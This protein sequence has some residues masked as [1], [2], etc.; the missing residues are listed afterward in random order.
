MYCTV[1]YVLYCVVLPC[2][3]LY[4]TVLP[5]L[6]YCLHCCAV[7]TAVLPVLSVLSV[8]LHC[9][10]CPV[11]TVLYLSQCC[12]IPV[13]VTNCSLSRS[14]DES[15]AGSAACLLLTQQPVAPGRYMQQPGAA[16]VVHSPV[17]SHDSCQAQ[18]LCLPQHGITR[19][20]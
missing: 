15:A 14:V 7:C 11:C 12:L 19:V 16:A 3:V 10:Y 8:L 1:L 6:L 5:V 4:C 17:L 2:T 9:L 18:T 20:F 13:L